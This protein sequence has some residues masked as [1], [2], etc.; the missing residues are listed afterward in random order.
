[1]NNGGH[2]LIKAGNE[3]QLKNG[4]CART[5]SNVHL[6]IESL[7]AANTSYSSQ[8]VSSKKSSNDIESTNEIVV[9]NNLA[10]IENEEVVS[11]WIYTISGQLLQTIVGG[12]HDVSHLP[13]G[14]YIL[15]HRMS[16][17]SVKSEK[18]TNYK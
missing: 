10:S 7:C 5:G 2:L 12:L 3:I 13:S 8:R 11:T 14:M 4:F 9:D 16:D 17:G 6:K 1:M 15:Q 18:V